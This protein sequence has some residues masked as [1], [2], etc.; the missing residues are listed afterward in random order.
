MQN[1]PKRL[2][3]LIFP[4]FPMSCL[5]SAIEPLRAANEIAGRIAF[6]WSV[7][8]EGSER[9]ASSAAVIFEPD[10]ALEEA[11]DLDYLF[12][13]SGPA[14]EFAN[15]RKGRAAVRW[16]ARQGTVLGGVSGGIFP[17]ARSGLLEGHAVSVHWCYDAAFRTEFAD[18]DARAEVITLDR[19]RATAAGAAAAFDLMLML[20]ERD[21]GPEVMTEVACWFQHPVVRGPDV[22]QRLPGYRGDRTQ[23]TLPAA[24]AGAIRLFS[25]HVGEP[26]AIAEV[27]RRVGLS[28]RQL[29]RTFQQATGQTP[30]RY[31]RAVRLRN[32]RQLVQLTD[33]TLTEIALEVGYGSPT[34]LVRHY[35][36]AFGRTPQADR[37]E[38]NAFRERGTARRFAVQG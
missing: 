22:A 2:G 26:L 4:G 23:D 11:R 21:L 33:K 10:C 17:L 14:G 1:A 16:L 6:R 32:A 27:A 19:S 29:D 18:L 24:I 20:I 7:I 12:F 31:Y 13:L 35:V 37:A 25:D 30:L 36:E 34:P 38:R 3:F 5:T 15:P 28:V 9:V 8:G